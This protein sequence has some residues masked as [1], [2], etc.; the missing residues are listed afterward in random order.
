M[1]KNKYNN[2]Y[3]DINS[4]IAEDYRYKDSVN[5]NKRNKERRPKDKRNSWKNKFIEDDLD[6]KK[7]I[8]Y[9]AGLFS[10][11]FFVSTL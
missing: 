8:L 10:P 7:I 5:K 3:N 2:G 4:M 1:S 11:A 6:W 9:K